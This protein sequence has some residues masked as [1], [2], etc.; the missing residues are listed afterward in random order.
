ML[1]GS[2]R[3]PSLFHVTVLS[4]DDDL[5]STAIESPGCKNERAGSNFTYGAKGVFSGCDA[6]FVHAMKKCYMN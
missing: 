6:K 1:L 5:Q 4:G 3:S 2:L